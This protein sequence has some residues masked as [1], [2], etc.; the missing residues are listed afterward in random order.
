MP[1]RLNFRKPTTKGREKDAKEE[2]VNTQKERKTVGNQEENQGQHCETETTSPQ[3]EKDRE[4]AEEGD[5]LTIYKKRKNE[6]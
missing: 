4:E 3:R 1:A 6:T 5:G 2:A